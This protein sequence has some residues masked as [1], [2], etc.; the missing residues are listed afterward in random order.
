MERG[1]RGRGRPGADPARRWSS[2]PTRSRRA[3]ASPPGSGRSRYGA[4]LIVAGGQPGRG[5]REG[6]RRSSG[7]RG[8]AGLP[9]GAGG[10]GRGGQRGRGRRADDPARLAGRLPVR[11]APAA[12][13]VD[14]RRAA[15]PSTR[16]CASR[17]RTTKP[18]RYAVIYV[19][20]ADDLSAER[21][22]F[23][24]PRAP[25]WVRRAGSQVEG[26]HLHLRGARRRPGAPGADRPRADRDLPAAAATTSSTTRRGRTSGSAV[27]RAD[28]RPGSRRGPDQA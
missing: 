14:R 3:T 13:R 26:V 11:G 22:P 28:H 27:H 8:R 24:H 17:T 16:S 18:E 12:R 21:F 25:C 2:W 5:D 15:R 9:A 19:D 20:H 10:A 7:G 6:D 23:R 4:Q 1:H